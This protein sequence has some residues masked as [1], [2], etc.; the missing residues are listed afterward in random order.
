MTLLIEDQSIGT[1]APH[2]S[3]RSWAERLE[4]LKAGVLGALAISGGF[5]LLSRLHIQLLGSRGLPSDVWGWSFSWAVL[6]LSGFLFG[7]TYRYVIRQDSN[8]HLKSGATLAFGLVRG[9]AQVDRVWQI[10]GEPLFLSAIVVESL[11]LFM[12][13]RLLLDGAL[14]LGWLRP[15]GAPDGGD[16]LGF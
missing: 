7:V 13:S 2:D 6:A 1:D 15:F 11:L 16:P 10:Y 14:K 12:I 4:S 9:L 8:P 3:L 5:G